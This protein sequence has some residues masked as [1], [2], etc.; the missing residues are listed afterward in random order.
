M[1]WLSFGVALLAA[2]AIIGI[3]IGYLTRPG[4][5]APSFGLPLPGDGAAVAGWLR[6]KGVR[7]ISSGVLVLTF[8]ALRAPRPLGVVLLVLALSPLGDMTVVLAG[9]GRVRTALSVHGVTAAVMILAAVP[10]LLGAA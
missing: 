5:M 8:M 2:L 3:G 4:A 7:D 10:L 6:L 1:H 9:R